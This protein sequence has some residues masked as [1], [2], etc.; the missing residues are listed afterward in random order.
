MPSVNQFFERFRNPDGSFAGSVVDYPA[1]D[2]FGER[3]RRDLRGILNVQLK[4]AGPTTGKQARRQDPGSEE[5]PSDR[6]GRGL[7]RG[8]TRR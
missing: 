1:P 7:W 4:A 8:S 5:A 2:A 6:A 3:L